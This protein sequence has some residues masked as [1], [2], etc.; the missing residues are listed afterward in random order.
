[1]KISEFL[2]LALPEERRLPTI[3]GVLRQFADE[4]C[5]VYE[6]QPC[7]YIGKGC[8]ARLIINAD[9]TRATF[10]NAD[11]EQQWA[12]D[13]ITDC[14]RR[15]MAHPQVK[16]RRVYGQVGFNFAAHTRGIA[17]HAGEWPLL[18][19]TVPREELIFEQGNVTVSADTASECRRLCEWVKAAGTATPC[20][21]VTV[22][23]AD[24]GEAYQEQVARVVSAIR[25]GE[26][27]KA[28]VSRAIALP[29]R[30]DMPST[31]L[32]GR[33]A[34][35]PT[36]SFMFRQQ[37]REALGF[38]PELVMAVSGSKVVT[39]PLAGTRDR[40][41]DPQQNKEKETELLHDG[42]EVLEHILSVKE[43]IA[44]LA[45][46]C[47]PG[48]VVV[49]D[50]MSVRQRGSVQHLG[51]CVSGQLAESKD[52]WDAFTVLFPSITASGIP[53]N[54]ALSAIMQI[55]KTP[56]ELYSGAVLLL[57]ETR[58][59]AAL[60]LRSVFQDSQRC[61]IQAGAGII[62]QSTPEREL[63]ETREKLASIAPYLRVSA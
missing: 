45:V 8:L 6:R 41:G 56:R 58:F 52:A 10:I 55:E 15:F 32:C 48:S 1:M 13:S 3:C 23:T 47:Q 37:G 51:S 4:E 33:Q 46:V 60:V 57:E 62:A 35:T 43:A 42:K 39:E 7:W 50:L 63:T 24:N 38:S 61:W 11:G 53:K 40:M 36:R 12:V 34:N 54:A 29:S 28:I 49:E 16:G 19:L 20:N 31:L 17:Y 21:T 14:A 27:V 26:Y 18:T 5:Y 44:E 2:H 30:I 59:D 9:G 25:R 22:D